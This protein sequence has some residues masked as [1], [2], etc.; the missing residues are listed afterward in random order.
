MN[1]FPKRMLSL[2]FTHCSV[3]KIEFVSGF[4]Q[5][6]DGERDP[7]NLILIF[8][9]IPKLCRISSDFIPM[10]AEELFDTISCYFPISFKQNPNDT[11]KITAQD[12]SE[13]LR[14]C[15][16]AHPSKNIQNTINV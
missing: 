16:A 7:T 12:L 3:C 4:T 10:N 6:I 15:L 9:L 1:Y 2:P 5:A 14:N 13:S 11:R 8:T